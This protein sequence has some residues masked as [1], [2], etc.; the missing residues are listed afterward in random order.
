MRDIS[1]LDSEFIP[2]LLK[3][4]FRQMPDCFAAVRLIALLVTNRAELISFPRRDKC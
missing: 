3:I 4:I 2:G 1:V